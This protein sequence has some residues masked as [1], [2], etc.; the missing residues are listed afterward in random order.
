MVSAAD[1]CRTKGMK[2]LMAEVDA[3]V[4][5]YP[6]VDRDNIRHTLLLLREKPIDRLRRALIRGRGAARGKRRRK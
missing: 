5:R 3:I 1:D 6:G 4:R 2:S